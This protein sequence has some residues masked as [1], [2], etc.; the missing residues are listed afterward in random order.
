MYSQPGGAIL[1]IVIIA[2]IVISGNSE[3]SG[4]ASGTARSST[5]S[6]TSSGQGVSIQKASDV[7]STTTTNEDILNYDD[8]VQDNSQVGAT[9]GNTNYGGTTNN[10]SR[11]DAVGE[12]NTNTVKSRTPNQNLTPSTYV[13]NT[14]TNTTPRDRTF[15]ILAPDGKVY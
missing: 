8:N 5:T 11:N 2:L 4:S 10:I 7:Q 13:D 14:T 1:I 6:K 9:T 12:R 15:S 3:R